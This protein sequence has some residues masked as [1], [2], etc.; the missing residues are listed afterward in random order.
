MKKIILTMVALAGISLAA[1]SQGTVAFQNEN[2]INGV[3]DL[4]A[5]NGTLSYAT[6]FTIA[7]YYGNVD[8]AATT[9]A[10]GTDAYGQLTYS[11]FLAD[12][13]SA[14]LT[15]G[16]TAEADGASNPG[17]FQG[18]TVTAS[19]A[20]SVNDDIVIAAWT[21]DYS[22]LAAAEAGGAQVGILGFVN[23]LGAGGQSPQVPVLSGW[24]SL[25]GTPAVQ[26]FEGGNYPDLVLYSVPEPTTMALAG[27][28]GLSLFLL[29][30]K[31]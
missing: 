6:S 30:R 2:E 15:L 4:E 19:V 1:H 9:V 18:G 22:T 23:A 17:F 21:G 31:K 13:T 16:G 14:G 3:V 29:R 25:T 24:N 8:G 11:G 20:G 28:G 7:L 26:A 27:L 5:A 12:V 10:L